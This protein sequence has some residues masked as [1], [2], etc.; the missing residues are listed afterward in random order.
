MNNSELKKAIGVEKYSLVICEKSEAAKKISEALSD[1]KFKTIKIFNT[2]VFLVTFKKRNY[3]ICSA[4][5]HLYTLSLL[6]KRQK[7]P[8]Y[9][10]AWIP[11]SQSVKNRSRIVN[12]RIKVIKK[13]SENASEFILACDLDQEGETIGY[14]ILKYACNEKQNIAK[15]VKFSTLMK[16]DIKNAFVNIQDS[17]NVN[18]AYAGL[19][20]HTIDF[21]YGMNI[22]RALSRAFMTSSKKYRTLSIGRVQGPTIAYIVEN[23]L[24]KDSH[25]PLP[26]WSINTYIDSEKNHNGK[27][28][29]IQYIEQKIL[30][31]KIAKKI[32]EECK[33]KKVIV[34]KI[35]K[36]KFKINPPFP[37]NL[38]GLQKEAFRLYKLSPYQT[39][40][41]A[42]KL[43]LNALISYPR[44]NSQRLPYNL[45]CRRI[46]MDLSNLS[47]FRDVANKL[48][49]KQNVNPT[50]GKEL[51][52]AHPSIYPT[53]KTSIN[54]LSD[55]EKKVFKLIVKRFLDLF[56][57]SLMG[58]KIEIFFKIA[59]YDFYT[60]FKRMPNQ[61]LNKS[62]EKEEIIELSIGDKLGIKRMNIS[63]N[64]EEPVKSYNQMTLVQKMEKEEIGTKSTR[65]NII[66]TIIDRMYVNGN[67]LIPT[68]LAKALV[69]TLNEYSPEILSSKM[70]KKME[71]SLREIE[72]NKITSEQVIENTKKDLNLVIKSI[73]ENNKDI[74]KILSVASNKLDNKT[75]NNKPLG[76]CTICL[77]G[78]LIIT[79]N[80]K[81]R[82]LI[83]SKSIKN[84]CEM[85]SSLPKFGYIR[86]QKKGCV[87]CSW[88]KIRTSYKGKPWNFCSNPQC[89]NEKR[90]K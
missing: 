87:K 73:Q 59:K 33:G 15:R 54:N 6:K 88:P 86:I 69:S 77:E 38:S 62:V 26:F 24:A 45:D 37:F 83:C 27:W 2:N 61:D 75:I 14:N 66:R 90:K 7:L 85:K 20:R 58:Q 16:D 43:Y 31:H 78:D 53:G 1:N 49:K 32:L 57:E 84:K 17:I 13:L 30:Q 50:Q 81:N 10:Y 23:E 36:S 56:G 4:I 9:D 82:A 3:L 25:V 79:S 63:E 76:K 18:I 48:L 5:G 68:D 44:T 42:E 60:V 34:N 71:K 51:D 52:N 28:I 67:M 64:F 22:S 40:N 11:I 55:V 21:L 65:A 12:A 47:E 39:L 35:E 70:T 29:K 80:L 74:G 41:I 19:T 89:H 72:Q 46:I 8:V